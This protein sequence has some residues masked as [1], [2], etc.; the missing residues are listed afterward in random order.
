MSAALVTGTVVDCSYERLLKRARAENFADLT[1]RRFLYQSGFSKRG[2]PIVVLIGRNL[3]SSL[4]LADKVLLNVVCKFYIG[5][6]NPSLV[7]TFCTLN[8]QHVVS[9]LV[10]PVPFNVRLCD[11]FYMRKQLL[12]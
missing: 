6:V 7:N 2:E 3:P 5:V 12:L 1:A 4:S 9:G 11:T 10:F 8:E